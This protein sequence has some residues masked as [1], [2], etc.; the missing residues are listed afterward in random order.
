MIGFIG[1]VRGQ[2]RV[3]QWEGGMKKQGTKEQIIGR[4]PLT[5]VV[6]GSEGIAPVS[7]CRCRSMYRT[8]LVRIAKKHGNLRIYC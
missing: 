1:W 4:L 8:S 3:C 7:A 5:A 6:G 2:D